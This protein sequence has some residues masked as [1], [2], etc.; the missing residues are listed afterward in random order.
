MCVLSLIALGAI[1]KK[2]VS[3]SGLAVKM[4]IHGSRKMGISVAEE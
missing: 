1:V 4:D 3:E 2:E